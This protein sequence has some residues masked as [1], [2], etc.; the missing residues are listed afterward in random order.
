MMRSCCTLLK[1]FILMLSQ[2]PGAE[3]SQLQHNHWDINHD[4]HQIWLSSSL[5][6]V[7]KNPP[8]PTHQPWKKPQRWVQPVR[9][10]RT[11]SFS[12][13][14]LPS[15]HQ[16]LQRVISGDS[17]RCPLELVAQVSIHNPSVNSCS[18]ALGSVNTFCWHNT[19]DQGQ[20]HSVNT[21]RESWTLEESTFLF[22]GFSPI[23]CKSLPPQSSS[24]QSPKSH[25]LQNSG[26]P[27]DPAWHPPHL[28]KL[29]TT[30]RS[31]FLHRA[32]WT[33]RHLLLRRGHSAPPLSH[34]NQFSC[35]HKNQGI[36]WLAEAVLFPF[37]AL[38]KLHI[39][40]QHSSAE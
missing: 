4:H 33:T 8:I 39:L 38:G 5:Y 28:D 18:P 20:K 2:L 35:S 26:E 27:G 24:L 1:D 11:K 30:W 37:L 25:L 23:H 19:E 16:A 31:S 21:A 6:S 34:P 36:F 17:Q 10:S 29:S 40:D 12:A 7:L 15:L 13:S 9:R 3:H 32:P 14:T 22:M